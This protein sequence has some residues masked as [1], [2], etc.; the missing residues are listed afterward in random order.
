MIASGGAGA[1]EHFP[2]AVG[3]RRRRGAGGERL[4]LRRAEH[5]RGQ[6]RA[7][8]SGSPGALSRA[9][10]GWAGSARPASGVGGTGG[11]GEAIA[12]RGRKMWASGPIAHARRARCR[13]RPCRRAASRYPARSSSMLVR[14]SRIETKRR[15]AQRLTSPVI[16]PSRGPG[17]SRAPMYRP[18]ATAVEHDPADQVARRGPRCG[19]GVGSTASVGVHGQA[20]H[21]HVAQ[22]ADAGPLP[23]RDPEQQHQRADHDHDPAEAQPGVP[24]HAL[25]EHVP[26]VQAEPR[27]D[28]E[29]HADP[30]ERPGPG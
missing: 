27:L 15:P 21:H 24:G 9:P 12:S 14:T 30:V 4:P 10:T 3:G 22:R 11:A 25:V 1:V 13:G 28:H 5:R 26:G 18:V 2:P 16:S 20:D 7:A 29:G 6:G 23:Q 19:P 8:G 17:P